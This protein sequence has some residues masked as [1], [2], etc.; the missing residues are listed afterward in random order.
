MPEFV[1][2]D[3]PVGLADIDGTGTPAGDHAH[4]IGEIQRS[5]QVLG[6]V[7]S[8]ERQHAKRRVAA[9]DDRYDPSQPSV[10]AGS[11]GGATTFSARGR[12]R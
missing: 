7:V 10:W 6:E 8:V 12:M 3:V 1:R 4:S 5:L 9:H 2:K 11:G